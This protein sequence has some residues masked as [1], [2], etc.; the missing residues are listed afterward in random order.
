[1]CCCHAVPHR[2]DAGSRNA[3]GRLPTCKF[4]QPFPSRR[5]SVD[6]RC[7]EGRA[8]C[9]AHEL[10][11]VTGDSSELLPRMSRTAALKHSP[12]IAHCAIG[13][14]RHAREPG[15]PGAG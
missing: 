2:N 4:T 5:R 1:M 15:I 10:I 7:L 3:D 9:S 13:A 11:T 12:V 8:G 14:E 6:T